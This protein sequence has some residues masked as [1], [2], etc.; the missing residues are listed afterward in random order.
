MDQHELVLDY[1]YEC[2]IHKISSKRE[3]TFEVREKYAR[4]ETIPQEISPLSPLNPC[5]CI[6][7]VFEYIQ[8][9]RFHYHI[10]NNVDP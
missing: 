10:L 4:T 6:M 2:I 7:S 5:P 8:I 9:A 3:K 1:L